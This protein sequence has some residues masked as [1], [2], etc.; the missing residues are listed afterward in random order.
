[1]DPVV[2]VVVRLVGHHMLVLVRYEKGTLVYTHCQVISS[3][4]PGGCAVPNSKRVWLMRKSPHNRFHSSRTP[5]RCLARHRRLGTV[6]S[7]STD[8]CISERFAMISSLSVITAL[9]KGEQ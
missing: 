2:R 7:F 1:M 5:R 8:K 9:E 4:K 3:Y 6:M